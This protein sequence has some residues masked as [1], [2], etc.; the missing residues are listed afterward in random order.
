ML[1]PN[2]RIIDLHAPGNTRLITEYVCG[3][4]HPG[5][6]LGVTVDLEGEARGILG[7][8]PFDMLAF[9]REVVEL[10]E[11]TIHDRPGFPLIG[12]IGTRVAV[13]TGSAGAP[14]AK[15]ETLQNLGKGTRLIVPTIQGGMMALSTV[16]LKSLKIWRHKPDKLVP[17]AN[18]SLLTLKIKD[19]WSYATLSA[20]VHV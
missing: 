19:G 14:S 2:N 10:V 6:I 15:W 7:A 1:T 16:P 12:T 4:D 11:L 8:A 18:P 5:E 13:D 17:G 9:D 20:M 3:I